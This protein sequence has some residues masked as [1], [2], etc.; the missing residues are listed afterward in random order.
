MAAIYC[1]ARGGIIAIIEK[2]FPV[3]KRE[4]EKSARIDAMW[5]T[6]KLS[7]GTWDFSGTV[8]EYEAIK[9]LPA[10]LQL[11]TE[12]SYRSANNFE[13]KYFLDCRFLHNKN[14][15]RNFPVKK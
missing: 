7:F 10:V 1:C 13:I 15:E 2:S 5:L 12:T 11:T 4:M 8:I 9:H 3:I 14:H 6:Q